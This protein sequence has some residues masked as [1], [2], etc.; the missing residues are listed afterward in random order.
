MWGRQLRPTRPARKSFV[1]AYGWA[2]KITHGIWPGTSSSL[3]HHL[4]SA[5]QHWGSIHTSS[6]LVV[7]LCLE[8]Y[9]I[10]L[11]NIIPFNAFAIFQTL[12]LM[13]NYPL[14][15]LTFISTS[16]Q[17]CATNNRIKFYPWVPSVLS[18]IKPSSP[19]VSCIASSQ[20][21]KLFSVHIDILE[22]CFPKVLN[23]SPYGQ[24]VFFVANPATWII[25][26]FYCRHLLSPW[27]TPLFA[28]QYRARHYP[29][30]LLSLLCSCFYT[31]VFAG[32]IKL[33]LPEVCSVQLQLGRGY[34]L[35]NCLF[36]PHWISGSLSS[37][38]Y[39]AFRL[40]SLFF[41][42]PLL[43]AVNFLFP[44]VRCELTIYILSTPCILYILYNSPIREKPKKI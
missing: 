32:A 42:S 43:I 44:S 41:P 30:I 2:R 3:P 23:E 11:K 37:M 8:F 19:V 13:V 1:I 36:I 16:N 22:Y 4:P 38:A 25:L 14:P 35:G 33:G 27:P 6:L 5:L 17:P 29:H 7:S 34:L 39:P 9:S 21:Q 40:L 24:M 20:A 28:F 31:T 18:K 15:L 12:D 10:W 26:L